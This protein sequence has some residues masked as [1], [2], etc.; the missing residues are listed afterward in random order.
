MNRLF[1]L[2]RFAVAACALLMS[3]SGLKLTLPPVSTVGDGFHVV[4]LCVDTAR[5]SQVRR[6]YRRA[7]SIY[8]A[9]LDHLLKISSSPLDMRLEVPEAQLVAHWGE[10]AAVDQDARIRLRARRD[11]LEKEVGES[12]RSGA[13]PHHQQLYI[14]MNK[15]LNDDRQT[16]QLYTQLKTCAQDEHVLQLFWT[17]RLLDWCDERKDYS[18]ILTEWDVVVGAVEFAVET[19]REI[20]EQYG[21]ARESWD[22]SQREAYKSLQTTTLRRARILLSAAVASSDRN[23]TLR[24]AEIVLQAADCSD[25]TLGQLRQALGKAID[26]DTLHGLV[27]RCQTDRGREPTQREQ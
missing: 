17:M 24:A 16:L 10:L 20:G 13:F 22:E 14:A 5:E 6:D 15:A 23:K 9:C 21:S 26:A 2:T 1:F 12:V 11:T 8:E 25:D 4:S 18:P 3:C 19:Q 27:E 7:E